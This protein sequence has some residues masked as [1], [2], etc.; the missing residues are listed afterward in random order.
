LQVSIYNNSTE[1]KVFYILKTIPNDIVVILYDKDLNTQSFT[2][3]AEEYTQVS[4]IEGVAEIE[5]IDKEVLEDMAK[6]YVYCDEKQI[7]AWSSEFDYRFD[8]VTSFNGKNF[9]LSQ[10]IVKEVNIGNELNG[11]NI[12]FEV[13]DVINSNQKE[14][15]E[16]N[17]EWIA[18]QVNSKKDIDKTAFSIDFYDKETGVPFQTLQG[19]NMKNYGGL[20]QYIPRHAITGKRYQDGYLLYK[21][22]YNGEEGIAITSVQTQFK[23]LK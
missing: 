1:D 22:K 2:I 5:D 4:I 11:A 13:T 10:L 7:K 6:L 18:V 9:G 19:T 21:L 15:I 12:E 20:W 23:I 8:S 3:E 16:E 17:K 14:E